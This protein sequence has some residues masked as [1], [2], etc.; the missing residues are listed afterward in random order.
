MKYTQIGKPFKPTYEFA[1]DMLRKHL[2]QLGGDN[3]QEMNV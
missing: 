1:E 2:Q 3:R